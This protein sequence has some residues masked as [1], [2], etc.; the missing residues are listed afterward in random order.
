M[1]S[2]I[3]K[4]DE[5][6]EIR[7]TR[8]LCSLND[9]CAVTIQL[10]WNS[11]CVCSFV[12]WGSL[13][14]SVHANSKYLRRAWR[15]GPLRSLQSVICHMWSVW[16]VEMAVPSWSEP[17]MPYSSC[18]QAVLKLYS[19]CT[20]AVQVVIC[21]SSVNQKKQLQSPSSPLQPLCKLHKQRKL[22]E[23][24][25]GCLLV[26]C[27]VAHGL[28]TPLAWVAFVMNL[29]KVC[30]G[31]GGHASSLPIISLRGTDLCQLGYNYNST[32]QQRVHLNFKVSFADFEGAQDQTKLENINLTSEA[33]CQSLAGKL[34][35]GLKWNK[36]E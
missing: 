19:S 30:W 33:A 15:F 5:T 2:T 6:G 16:S 11:M 36:D 13:D 29:C 34:P 9:F 18:T 32:G 28:W 25:F 20:Q 31:C 1:S 27:Y 24:A 35:K 7:K 10:F 21:T 17:Y 22:W 8:C 14:S 26:V 12:T 3:S 4:Q 23:S